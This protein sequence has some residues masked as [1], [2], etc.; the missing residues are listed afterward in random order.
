MTKRM[1]RN[2]TTEFKQDVVILSLSRTKY[3]EVVTFRDT[4]K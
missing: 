4:D 2:D 3:V 1:S